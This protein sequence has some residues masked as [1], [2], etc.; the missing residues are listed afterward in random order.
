MVETRADFAD[1]E[2]ELKKSVWSRDNSLLMTGGEDGVG[3]VWKV[4]SE[5]GK[6]T[7][8]ERLWELR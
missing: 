2:S 4:A 5:G 6:V 3:R 7:G 1:E 8:L